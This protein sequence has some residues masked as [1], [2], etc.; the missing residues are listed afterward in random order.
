MSAPEQWQIDDAIASFDDAIAEIGRRVKAQRGA[1]AE[2][3][4]FR[5]D[6]HRF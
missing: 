3:R 1:D 6:A 2:H 5:A 4:L